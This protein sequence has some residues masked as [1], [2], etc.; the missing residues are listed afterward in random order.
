MV[1]LS[2]QK[3]LLSE[4]AFQDY[5]YHPKEQAYDLNLEFIRLRVYQKT[6]WDQKMVELVHKVKTK[7][8]VTGETRIKKQFDKPAEASDFLN[9]YVLAF[10]YE[11]TGKE[12][13]LENLRIFLE[14][15]E[16]LPP[17]IE[18][19]AP[20]KGEIEKFF[21]NLPSAG[22]VSDSIPIPYQN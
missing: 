20:S 16:G 2:Y 13:R 6:N 7:Q 3:A 14:D 9:S 22:V 15:I 11:R 5:I 12:Y 10:S 1:K 17:S 4:Y 18:V 8:G 19:L 21:H